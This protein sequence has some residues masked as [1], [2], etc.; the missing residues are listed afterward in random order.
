MNR[1]FTYAI[2]FI[3]F[4]LV[5]CSETSKDLEDAEQLIEVAPDS[6]LHILQLISPNKSMSE[7]DRALY[8]LL[9]FQA[10][11]KNFLPLSPDTLINFSIYYYEQKGEI[12]RLATACLYKARVYKYASRYEDATLLLMKALDNA[13]RSKDYTLLGRVYS[14]LGE[15]CFK[16]HDYKKARIEYSQA[17][18]F[19]SKTTLKR[20]TIEALLAIGSTY[21]AEHKYD[22]A[23]LYY[24]QVLQLAPD[25]LSTG[26]CMQEIAQNYYAQQKY[27]SALHYLR[28]LVHY[29]YLENNRAKR[30]YVLADVYFDVRQLDSAYLFACEALKFNPDIN[31]RQGCYRILGN[32]AFLQKKTDEMAHYLKLYTACSDT[33]KKIESQTKVSVLEKMNQDN[34]KIRVHEKNIIILI[35]LLLLIFVFSGIII[36][37]LNTKHRKSKQVQDIQIQQVHSKL[38]EKQSTLVEDLKQKI[39]KERNKQASFRKKATQVERDMLVLELYQATLHLN[40]WEEF[41]RLMNYT[42]NNIVCTLANSCPDIKKVDIIW[43]CLH[44]LDVS[45]AERMIV[46]NVSSGSLYK[47]KQRLALKLQLKGAKQLDEYLKQFNDIFIS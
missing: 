31:T 17:Y 27:D 10:L 12:S 28:H 4:A 15:I 41:T 7:S 44:L 23:S 13:D 8:G 38:I 1:L 35:V 22:S 9:I 37:I 20:H 29:P 25:S 26:N 3:L 14:D 11:D 18:K 39:E 5:G 33:I 42:F 21:F 34:K 46:L 47:I 24:R 2:L 40:D 32:T 6:A 19:Y 16:Q 43:C 36:Y 30:Y 45:Q